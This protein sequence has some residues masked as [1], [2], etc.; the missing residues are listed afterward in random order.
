MRGYT[1]SLMAHYWVQGTVPDNIRSYIV[2]RFTE[3]GA[4]YRMWPDAKAVRE[5]LDRRAELI[6]SG[7]FLESEKNT[8]PYEVCHTIWQSTVNK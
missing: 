7:R 3:V 2:P 6:E 1:M 5:E 8:E 4:Y